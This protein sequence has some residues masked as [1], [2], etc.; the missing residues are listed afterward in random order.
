VPPDHRA[1]VRHLKQ[2]D[3]RLAGVIRQVG[4]CRLTPTGGRFEIVAR[5]IVSQQISVAAAKTIFGRLKAALPQGRISAAGLAGLSDEQ[6]QQIGLSRQKRTYLRDLVQRTL[7]G[8]VRFRRFPRVADE[9]VIRELTAVKGIGVWT[10]QMFLM[11]G[12]GRPDVFAPG[13]L[14]LQNAMNRLYANGERLPEDR[15]IELAS[16][17]APYRSI[18]CWYLWRSLETPTAGKK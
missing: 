18:A 14:G 3:Q 2:A 1:A 10:A 9:V 12:L 5:S 11:F 16:V 13:D 4:A 6:L 7:D 8:S 15:L 17:W